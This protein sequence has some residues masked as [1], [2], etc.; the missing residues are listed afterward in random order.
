MR[1][2]NAKQQGMTFGGLVFVLA[3]IAIVVLF[4][5]RAFPLY[6]EKMQ[7]LSA[8]NAVADRPDAASMSVADIRNAFLK[9]IYATTNLETFSDKTVREHVEVV[10]PQKAG[11]PKMLRVHYDAENILFQDLYL[12]MKF[13]QKKPLHGNAGSSD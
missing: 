9:N 5:V 11:E 2:S 13:D 4:A 3:F 12:T 1:H 8:M 6:N 10:D 7:V